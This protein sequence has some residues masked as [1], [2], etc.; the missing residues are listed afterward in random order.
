MKLRMNEARICLRTKW[1]EKVD[2]MVKIVIEGV[3][4]IINITE[5]RPYFND[6]AQPNCI[7]EDSE[8]DSDV[9]ME[10]DLS[11]SE[12]DDEDS[13]AEDLSISEEGGEESKAEEDVEADGNSDGTVGENL[14]ETA[15]RDSDSLFYSSLDVGQQST[16]KKVLFYFTQSEKGADI[17]AKKQIAFNEDLGCYGCSR[18]DDSLGINLPLDNAPRKWARG[19]IGQTN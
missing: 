8:L 13:K 7:T 15:K 11:I 14:I 2:D 19:L 17:E 12:E 4:F 5:F 16:M 10:E 3:D 18:V 9:Q 6:K 1:M